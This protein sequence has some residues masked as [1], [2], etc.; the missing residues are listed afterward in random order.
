VKAVDSFLSVGGPATAQLGWVS[1][2][3]NRT[4]AGALMPASFVSTHS[5]PTDYR[6][7]ADMTRSSFEDGVIAAAQIAQAANLPFVLTEMSAGLNN[8]Y[9]SYFAA[10]FIAH[11][12]AAFLGVGGIS[13]MSFWTFTDIFEERGMQSLPYAETFGMQTKWGVPKPSYR[14]LQLLSRLP[15]TGLPVTAAGAAPRRAGLGPAGGATAT[16]GNVDAIAAIDASLGTT[17]ALVA[18]VTNFNLNIA[19]TEDPT[20]GLPIATE[21]G[22]TVTWTLPAGAVA[23]RVAGD[24]GDAAA[25][26]GRR[27]AGGDD[28][29]GAPPPCRI[30]VCALYAPGPRAALRRGPGARAALLALPQGARLFGSLQCGCA[31]ARC[32][33]RPFSSAL[34]N[35]NS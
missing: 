6:H 14:A 28:R 11:E 3:I 26:G 34:R 35:M 13:T 2:F 29:R 5:Y 7:D 12:A 1:E 4:G 32:R 21:A 10:S 25:R 22:V 23:R 27:A 30:H 18:L 31:F 33:R 17:V 15:K 20:K 9:D 8:A 24:D 19:D 16:V